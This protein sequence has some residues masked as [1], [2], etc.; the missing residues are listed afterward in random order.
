SL[1]SILFLLS[2]HI[3]DNVIYVAIIFAFIHLSTSFFMLKYKKFNFKLLRILSTIYVFTI[4][5]NN[6]PSI[7]LKIALSLSIFV[8]LSILEIKIIK[9]LKSKK[10]HLNTFIALE[11]HKH[12]SIAKSIFLLHSFI[13]FGFIFNLNIISYGTAVSLFFHL[14]LSYYTYKMLKE[15][16]N[17]KKSLPALVA[18]Y[19]PEYALYFSAPQG[20]DFQVTM[21]INYLEKLSGRFIIILR[22]S[23]NFE[24]ISNITNCPIISCPRI[25]NLDECITKSLSTI[26]YVNNG[27]KN[28]HMVR[29]FDLT[30]IQLLHGDSDKS[31]SYN[32][33]TAMYD[34]IFVAGQLGIDRYA[35]NGVNIP[36][37]KFEIV[38]R[39]Q[40]EKIDSLSTTSTSEI[41]TVLYAPTWLGYNSDSAYSSIMQ[42]EIIIKSLLNIGN[43]RVIVKLHP[44]LYKNKQTSEISKKLQNMLIKQN[45]SDQLEHIYVSIDNTE[46][47]LFDYFNLCDCLISDVSSV[48]SDF[49]FS[50]KPMC[51]TDMMNEKE[52]IQK[53]FP[54]SAVSYMLNSDMKNISYCLDELLVKDS[55]REKRIEFKKYVLGDFETS[56]YSENFTQIANS[57]ISTTKSSH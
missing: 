43:V 22:E 26:F 47:D 25:A 24:S 37:E 51:I 39:P 36:L 16:Q 52:N 44:Y 50:G 9:I 6:H 23:V 17:I 8:F 5:I 33:V 10:G 14:I 34:K 57:L 40:L 4:I 41:Q 1:V 13:L 27:M 45:E 55:K 56:T 2:L 15:R 53:T 35:N 29:F 28:T 49:L 31:P 21:W 42:A 38:G 20:S 18:N 54:I 11:E 30:H 12:I 19:N 48:A 46:L 3:S 7:P 32:P